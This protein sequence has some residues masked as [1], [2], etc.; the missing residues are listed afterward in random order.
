MPKLDMIA[1]PISRRS[2]WKTLGDYLRETDLLLDENASV[3]AQKRVALVRD[4]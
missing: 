4:P 2:Y 3:G 1:L